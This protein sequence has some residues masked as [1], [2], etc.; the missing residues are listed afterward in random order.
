MAHVKKNDVVFILSGKD[1][2]K[3]GTV[4]EVLP[5]KGKVKVKGIALVTRHCKARRQGEIST[6]K[7][8]ESYIDISNVIPVSQ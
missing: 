8:M 7:K 1:K 2:G 4:I 5:K 6:I 3:R